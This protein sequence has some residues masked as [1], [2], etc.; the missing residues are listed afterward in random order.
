MRSRKKVGRGSGDRK[1]Q[2]TGFQRLSGNAGERPDIE[3]NNEE[4][5]GIP[6]GPSMPLIFRVREIPPRSFSLIETHRIRPRWPA[7]AERRILKLGDS[8]KSVKKF[9]LVTFEGMRRSRKSR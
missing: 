9:L 2:R 6:V 5:R 1:Q 3:K 4:H 8:K 7:S